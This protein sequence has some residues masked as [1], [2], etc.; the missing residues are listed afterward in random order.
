MIDL[1]TRYSA[2]AVINSK[3]KEVIVDAILKHWVAVFGTPQSIF[4]DNGGEFNNELLRDVAELLD[5]SVA[6]TAAE[7]PWSNGVVE[8]HNATL[9][10]MIH[11]I[12]DDTNCSIQNALVWALSAKNALSNNLGYSPNQLVFGRNPNL[13]STLSSQ[14]PALRT[15]TSS[16]LVAEH[17]NALHSARRAFIQAE[18]SKKIKTALSRQTRTT[19]SKDFRNGDIVYYKRNSDND[20]HGPGT[21][22][23]I[24]GK[25][26]LV[27]HGGSILRV[28]PC[29]LAKTN[30]SQTL[31]KEILIFPDVDVDQ[32]HAN[33]PP[34]SEIDIAFD[35]IV[36][37]PVEN[38]AM[39]TQNIQPDD[40]PRQKVET[41]IGNV[42]C[43]NKRDKKTVEVH[44]PRIGQQ[45]NFVDPD[46]N[47]KE[48]FI[49]VNRAGK[50]TGK[51]KYWFNVK[52]IT[53]GVIKCVDF[54]KVEW[55]PVEEEVL[56]SSNNNPQSK[57]ARKM[58]G[59]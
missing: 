43:V 3:H 56:Y 7:S 23:G 26:V 47:K 5:V 2:A 32:S 46:T 36:S 12:V 31:P 41:D 14:L 13:P 39:Q 42:D 55:N 25:V 49:V 51:N 21:I 45:I 6:S 15:K 4:A 24:D 54:E 35:E 18:S 28:S 37:I 11:K 8:R 9:G 20:W 38:P 33:T 30:R 19:T 59:L 22:I 29:H 44:H 53:F 1:F 57:R 27:R 10:N 40:V 58:E 52:N 34:L 17:L 48:K 50:A 16:E